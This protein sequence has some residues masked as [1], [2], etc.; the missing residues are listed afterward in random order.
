MLLEGQA[1]QVHQEQQ[2]LREHRVHLEW[3][4]HQDQLVLLVL[5]VLQGTRGRQ[6]PL[7]NLERLELVAHKEQ[8]DLR[9]Q[10][11]LQDQQVRLE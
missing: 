8:V 5:P 11:V 7:V 3:L 6:D 10:L 4:E 2:E 1:L 9:D